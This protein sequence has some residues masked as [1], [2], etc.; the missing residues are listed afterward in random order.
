LQ[1]SSLAYTNLFGTKRL[2]CCIPIF[3]TKRFDLVIF[4]A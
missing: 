2:C 4:H 3:G 1:V